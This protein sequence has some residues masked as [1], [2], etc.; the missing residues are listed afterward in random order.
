M[1]CRP[2]PF[3]DLGRW[4]PRPTELQFVCG[5]ASGAVLLTPAGMTSVLSRG[6]HGA[7]G[8]G[9]FVTA[10]M[11]AEGPGNLSA[12]LWDGHTLATAGPIG[13]GQTALFGQV[14]NGQANITFRGQA[15]AEPLRWEVHD[16]T[17][18]MIES[19]R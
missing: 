12:V 9:L 6:Y 2:P 8:D 17:V 5:F 13:S 14:P 15:G 4:M 10:T 18:S 7:V 1:N 16:V 11:H 19:L 3:E